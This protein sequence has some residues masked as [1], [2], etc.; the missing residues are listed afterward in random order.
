MLNAVAACPPPGLPFPGAASLVPPQVGTPLGLV[1][2]GGPFLGD[3]Q[4]VPADGL[5]MLPADA[6]GDPKSRQIKKPKQ[7]AANKVSQQRYRCARLDQTGWQGQP[8]DCRAGLGSAQ[9]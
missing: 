6:L 3:F 7:Q 5:T 8:A 4:G 1:P 2:T 9:S